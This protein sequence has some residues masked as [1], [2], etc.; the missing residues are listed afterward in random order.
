MRRLQI[1]GGLVGVAFLGSNL[2][3]AWREMAADP[4]PVAWPRVALATALL[5]LVYG[6]LAAMWKLMARELGARV[7]FGDALQVVSI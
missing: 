5:A 2:A 4:V 1:L 6:G 3:D 7:A